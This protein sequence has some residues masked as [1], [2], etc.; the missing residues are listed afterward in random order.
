[1]KLT[2]RFLIGLGVSSLAAGLIFAPPSFAQND[3]TTTTTTESSASNNGGVVEPLKDAA[4]SVAT[5][6]KNAYH[7]VKRSVKDEALEG[8]VK[9]IL[10]ENKD[11]RDI[12]DVDVEA[13]HGVVT[14]SGNVGSELESIRAAQVASEV[15]GVKS[16]RNDLRYPANSSAES[17]TRESARE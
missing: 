7:K 6:T 3:S 13:D 16:V 2:K 1:M 5:G 12:G 17:G 14:L 15:S 10:H 9:A 4:H 11:T 8:K